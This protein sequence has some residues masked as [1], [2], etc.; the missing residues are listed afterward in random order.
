ML[1]HNPQ[2]PDDTTLVV[3]LHNTLEANNTEHHLQIALYNTVPNLKKISPS[4]EIYA[5]NPDGLIYEENLNFGAVIYMPPIT[6]LLDVSVLNDQSQNEPGQLSTLKVEV[7]IS[8]PVSTVYSTLFFVLQEP[9]KFSSS[10]YLNTY[11]SEE[12]ATNPIDLNKAPRIAFFEIKSPNV[13]Y[14]VFNETFTANRKFIVEIT[15]LSNPFFI[16]ESNISIY[17]ADFNSLTPLEAY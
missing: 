13:F 12:Y 9:F 2:L 15:E 1:I 14:A 7:N 6:N 11:E 5:I 16:A 10:S 4:I 17:S 3:K 8:I